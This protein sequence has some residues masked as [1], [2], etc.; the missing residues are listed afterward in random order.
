MTFCGQYGK[1]LMTYSTILLGSFQCAWTTATHGM[2]IPD[3]I[4]MF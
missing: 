1:F 2:H 3:L 4:C